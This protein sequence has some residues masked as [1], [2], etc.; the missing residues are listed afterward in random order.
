MLVDPSTVPRSETRT[1]LVRRDQHTQRGVCAGPGRL[2][3]GHGRVLG[4]AGLDVPPSGAVDLQRT[5]HRQG[6]FFF[7]AADVL[8]RVGLKVFLFWSPPRWC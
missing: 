6:S 8:E 2:D 1:S 3:A 7:V 4:G 5:L